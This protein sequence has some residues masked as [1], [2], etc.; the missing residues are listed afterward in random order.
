[1]ERFDT[2]W[3]GNPEEL[4]EPEEGWFVYCYHNGQRS[5]ACRPYYEVQA[6]SDG[7]V[8]ALPADDLRDGLRLYLTFGQT[9]N[10]VFARRGNWQ[11]PEFACW[12]SNGALKGRWRTLRFCAGCP[13][14]EVCG[15]LD[16]RCRLSKN[17]KPH[18]AFQP[19]PVE[20]CLE[21]ASGLAAYVTALQR[22]QVW[23]N[24]RV[25]V[26]GLLYDLHARCWKI[27]CDRLQGQITQP[28]ATFRQGLEVRWMAAIFAGRNPLYAVTSWNTDPAQLSTY[29]RVQYSIKEQLAEPEDAPVPEDAIESIINCI[30]ATAE[31][32]LRLMLERCQQGMPLRESLQLATEQMEEDGRYHTRVLLGMPKEVEQQLPPLPS[33]VELASQNATKRMPQ[34]CKS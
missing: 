30:A 4:D 26:Y 3:R 5:E 2:D 12:R 8:A 15:H 14:P 29:I 1:M 24:D 22:D 19:K 20:Q 23:L 13:D 18:H 11:R 16:Q 21:E 34:A 31:Y 33:Y 17:G 27:W 6:T 25:T 32:A 28:E 7:R 10:V 9:A